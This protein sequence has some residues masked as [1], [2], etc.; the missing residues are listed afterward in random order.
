MTFSSALRSAR[1]RAGLTQAELAGRLGISQSNVAEFERS[2]ALSETTVRRYATALGLEARLSLV[3]PRR[4]KTPPKPA[5]VD[6][7]MCGATD[8]TR[9]VGDDGLERNSCCGCH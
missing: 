4:T 7:C 8:Y 2:S 1:E 5:Q 3:A 6:P 9:A